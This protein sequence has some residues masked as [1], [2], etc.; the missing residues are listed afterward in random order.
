MMSFTSIR[1]SVHPFWTD[2][3]V[4]T[5]LSLPGRGSLSD[6]HGG[7]VSVLAKQ[8]S[9]LSRDP[10]DSPTVCLECESG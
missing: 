7:V 1:V 8:A 9:A 5:L 2:P 3:K 4:M 6:E 10:T